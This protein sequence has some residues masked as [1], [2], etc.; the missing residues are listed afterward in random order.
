MKSEP[1]PQIKAGGEHDPD[2][3]EQGSESGSSQRSS[4]NSGSSKGQGKRFRR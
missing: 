4:L 3:Q 1:V 2:E